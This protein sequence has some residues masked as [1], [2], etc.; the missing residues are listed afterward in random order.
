MIGLHLDPK[1]ATQ[2]DSKEILAVKDALLAFWR[3]FEERHSVEGS[4]V[5]NVEE[6]IVGWHAHEEQGKIFRACRFNVLARANQKTAWIQSW[7][8]EPDQPD[9]E[10]PDATHVRVHAESKVFLKLDFFPPLFAIVGKDEEFDVPS[11]EVV[12][13][14][15]LAL[16][17][18]EGMVTQ[19]ADQGEIAAEVAER[20]F[21]ANRIDQKRGRLN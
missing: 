18:I 3:D 2:V 6:L 12:Q 21:Q 14:L 16:E 11:T 5:L 4:A 20:Q 19:F 10:V 7:S 17:K 9:P 15:S 1:V 13:A 8:I